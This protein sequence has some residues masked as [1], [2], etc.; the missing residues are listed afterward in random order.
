MATN[1]QIASVMSVETSKTSDAPLSTV[2]VATSKGTR[3][4][5]ARFAGSPNWRC[6]RWSQPG[7]EAVSNVATLRGIA[8]IINRIQRHGGW[9]DDPSGPYRYRRLAL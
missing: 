2:P 1:I 8:D 5:A 3:S 4:R 7:E 9:R 6:R